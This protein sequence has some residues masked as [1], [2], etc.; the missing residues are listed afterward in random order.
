MPHVA[1][2]AWNDLRR[3]RLTC[4][5][6]AASSVSYKANKPWQS[7]FAFVARALIAG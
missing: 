7:G 4:G 3:I 1:Y 6:E 5:Q 2:L